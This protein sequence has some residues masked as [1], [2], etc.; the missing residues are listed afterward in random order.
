VE[1]PGRLV[2]KFNGSMEQ[3]TCLGFHVKAPPLLSLMWPSC[4][5]LSKTCSRMRASA[6]HHEFSTVKAVSPVATGWRT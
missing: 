3:K 6:T 4:V 1:G 2:I 5:A